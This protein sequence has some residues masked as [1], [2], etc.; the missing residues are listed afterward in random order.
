MRSC[1]EEQEEARRFKE[2][3]A[4]RRSRRTSTTSTVGAIAAVAVLVLDQASKAAVFANVRPG[5]Q[6]VL[7]PLLSILPGWNQGTAFGFAQ[8]TAPLLLIALALGVS[9]WLAALIIQP[10]SRLEGAA[11]GAAI[12]GALANVADRVR[13]GAVRDFIDVHWNALHWPTFNAADLL[14]SV[15]SCSSL[16]PIFSGS[17]KRVNSVTSCRREYTTTLPSCWT[18]LGALNP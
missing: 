2:I 4:G 13:F 6:L 8:G 3:A 9:A 1:A 10:T 11:L 16:S 17:G 12:G 18:P 5:E 15:A 14:S 7:A